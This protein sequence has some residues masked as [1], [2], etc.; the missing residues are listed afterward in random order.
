MRVLSFRHRIGDCMDGSSKPSYPQR[1]LID[2][3]GARRR[4]IKPCRRG[5]RIKSAAGCGYLHL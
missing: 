2:V 1:H 5:T 3:S 4:A